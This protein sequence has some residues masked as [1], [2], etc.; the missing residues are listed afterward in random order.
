[1]TLVL[2]VRVLIPIHRSRKTSAQSWTHGKSTSS[3][4]SVIFDDSGRVQDALRGVRG[5]TNQNTTLTL[6]GRGLVVDHG[7]GSFLT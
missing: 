7:S 2:K 3:L 4:L 6:T 1:M 5:D